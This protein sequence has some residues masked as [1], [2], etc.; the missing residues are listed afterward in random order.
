MMEECVREVWRV[1]WEAYYSGG[2][3]GSLFGGFLSVGGFL[4][5]VKGFVLVKLKEGVFDTDE[6]RRIV[7]RHRQLKPTVSHYGP[8]ERLGKFL[9][10]AVF[11]S[12]ATA[13]LQFTVGLVEAGWALTVCL[14]AAGLSMCSLFGGL[15]AMKR[16]LDAWFA[17]L[18][19][20][21]RTS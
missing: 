20:E 7:E 2:L 11:L 13:V 9:F 15:L 12:F 17:Q 6:Y 4:F 1:I 19:K 14:T 3:R 21:S 18:E 10:A 8:L 5:S 16:F